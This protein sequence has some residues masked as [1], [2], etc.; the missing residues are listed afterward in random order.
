MSV[1]YEWVEHLLD[2]LELPTPKTI[3]E[4]Q[5]V[6]RLAS[7]DQFVL[8]N[9]TDHCLLSLRMQV[10]GYQQEA[11]AAQLLTLCDPQRAHPYQIR[12]GQDGQNE[13]I[14]AIRLSAIDHQSQDLIAAFD[15]LWDTRQDLLEHQAGN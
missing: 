5:L 15:V 6:V 8:E 10:N 11:F 3:P 4:D 7:D 12:I 9:N 14:I 1:W 13:F 2:R